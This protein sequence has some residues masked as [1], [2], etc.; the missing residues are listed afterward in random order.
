[1]KAVETAEAKLKAEA[2]D[3]Y[4]ALL[5]AYE[6]VDE[7]LESV[8]PHEWSAFEE[9]EKALEMEAFHEWAAL[10]R[11]RKIKR[12]RRRRR[13]GDGCEGGS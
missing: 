5:E 4:A 7:K 13:G 1:M 12:R 11:G 10:K 8:P 9:A 2:P 3:A 6:E